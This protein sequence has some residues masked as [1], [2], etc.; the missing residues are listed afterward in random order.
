MLQASPGRNDRRRNRACHLRVARVGYIC[1]RS[2]NRGIMESN[3]VLRVS[4]GCEGGRLPTIRLPASLLP[5]Y[6]PID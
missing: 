2:L 5:K 1:Y 6:L 4:L 3:M